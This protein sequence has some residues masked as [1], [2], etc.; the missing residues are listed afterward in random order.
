MTFIYVNIWKISK[1]DIITYVSIQVNNRTLDQKWQKYDQKFVMQK[2][3]SANGYGTMNYVCFV[4][5]GYGNLFL[6]SK[7]VHYQTTINQ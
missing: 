6:V 5:C 4:N 3:V 2:F 7:H 1:S